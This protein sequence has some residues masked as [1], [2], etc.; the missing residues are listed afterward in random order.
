MRGE[1]SDHTLQA[2]ALVNEAYLRLSE[3]SRIRWQDRRHFF[4]MAVR[5]MRRVLVDYARTRLMQK[6]GAGV[7]VVPLDAEAAVAVE[8]GMD[9][10]ALDDALAALE[11]TMPRQA[12]VVE[13]RYFGGMTV[14]ET[15]EV[16]DISVETVARD[17]R[18]AR[19]WLLRELAGRPPH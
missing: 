16:L 7:A 15:A 10:V 8:R 11:T 4:A 9:V 12:R 3:L 19:L 2:T 1:R 13:L 14:A 5:M 18:A 6:R 17:W